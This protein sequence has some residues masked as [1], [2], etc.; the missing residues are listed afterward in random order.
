MA[1]EKPVQVD[2][3]KIN[4]LV[5]LRSRKAVYRPIK[6]MCVR[7]ALFVVRGQRRKLG[8][9]EGRFKHK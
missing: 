2:L 7:E 5:T 8:G 4:A 1:D 3:C 9:E 6:G